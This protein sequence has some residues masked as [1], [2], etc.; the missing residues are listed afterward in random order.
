VPGKEL[1]ENSILF[2]QIELPAAKEEEAKEEDNLI[3]I[4]DFKKVQLRTAVVIHAEKVEKS[5][6]LLKLKVKCGNKEK[7]II[8]GI[9]EF[10][11]PE[12]IL[13][14]SI[15]IVDNLKPAKLMGLESQGMLL[16]AK[17]DGKLKIISADGEF[18]DGADVS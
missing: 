17:A 13:N 9:A 14:K 3:S 8:A 2:P 12:E 18:T 1:G 15:V 16:A 7:Q 11:T 4:D 5:K 6:K 10:Y